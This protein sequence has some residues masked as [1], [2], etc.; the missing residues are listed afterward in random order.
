MLITWYS[1]QETGTTQ[2]SKQNQEAVVSAPSGTL[3]GCE[4]ERNHAACCNADGSRGDHAELRESG[5]KGRTH[6]DLPRV[7]LTDIQPGSNKVPEAT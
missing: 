1:S 6:T 7:G 4:N 2:M 5:G 3:C